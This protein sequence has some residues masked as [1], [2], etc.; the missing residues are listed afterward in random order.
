MTDP[1]ATPPADPCSILFTRIEAQDETKV[2]SFPTDRII[3]RRSQTLTPEE[4]LNGR[5]P[6][7]GLHLKQRVTYQDPDGT[8]HLGMLTGVAY[9]VDSTSYLVRCD[10]G[11]DRVCNVPRDTPI[12]S[13]DD[14]TGAA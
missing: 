14:F 6:I 9:Y 5:D 8:C 4:M 10:D 7:T 3:R 11:Q 13:P 2:V 1:T 12:P